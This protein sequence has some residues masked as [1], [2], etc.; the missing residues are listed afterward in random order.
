MH[1]HTQSVEEQNTAIM[2]KELSEKLSELE[3]QVHTY[4]ERVAYHESM[5]DELKK[6]IESQ[7]D[8]V[9]R[10]EE[11]R[12]IMLRENKEFRERNRQLET[13]NEEYRSK[14]EIFEREL[15]ELQQQMKEEALTRQSQIDESESEKE[16]K[17]LNLKKKAPV[18][19]KSA[20]IKKA[21][22]TLKFQPA[23]SKA[24][25]PIVDTTTL[26]A[27]SST[28]EGG[29]S[30]SLALDNQI[31]TQELVTLN[32]ELQK[33]RSESR[34]LNEQHKKAEKERLDLKKAVEAKDAAL[35]KLRKEKDEL[36]AIVNTDKYRNIKQLETERDKHH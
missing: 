5:E 30:K 6:N 11:E 7:V 27:S 8:V 18:M 33:L 24:A 1:R 20:T 21:T 2:V 12:L 23:M 4:R 34:I 25:A 28:Q 35:E 16:N 36:W 9:L 10:M 31:L 17:S 32:R 29:Q 26:S 15:E 14:I 22:S 19:K 3:T 13:D